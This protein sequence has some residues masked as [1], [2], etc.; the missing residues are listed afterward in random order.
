MLTKGG[1]CING[2]G[3]ELVKQVRSE[4]TTLVSAVS[5]AFCTDAVIDELM[6]RR[7]YST[8][9]YAAE[10][11][12]TLREVGVF[13]VNYLS[14]I[15]LV[16]PELT[17][18]KA[19]LFGLV[20][21][22]GVF[23]LK[24]RFCVPIR[25]I[26]GNVTAIVGWFPDSRKYITTATY[27]FVRDAQFFNIECYKQSIEKFGGTVFLVEGI[28]DTLALRAM[29]YPALGNM[30]LELSLIKSQI[31]TRFRKVV[32]IP[33]NDKAGK[34]TNEF[35]YKASGKGR[36]FRWE[37]VN[38]HV[39]VKLPAGV[40]DTDDFVKFYDCREDLESCLSAR[41]LKVLREE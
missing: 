4:M 20:D 26:A 14:E 5:N 9:L 11:E 19:K 8:S 31:L 7:L 33:D 32:A 25:D 36:K 13:Q 21:D 18:E 17:M 27:G 39:V 24:G 22:N 23:L 3:A 28:F 16:Y 41:Y 38:E 29:G 12:A 15:Q 34:A 6:S 37:I 40:K 30:G 1:D 35:L 2:N 10:L